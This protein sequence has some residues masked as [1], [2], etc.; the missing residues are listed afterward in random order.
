[1]T[2]LQPH[3][4][5]NFFHQITLIPRPSKKEEKI[6]AFLVDFAN[7][8]QLSSVK[9][10]VGNLVISKP[11]TSAYVNH[12]TVIL[13]AHIDMVC[14]KNAD[15][16]H[17]F[18]TDAIQTYIDGD[19]IKA[20]GTTL[21]ADNGIGVA[22]MLAVLA[23]DN[24][25]HP[26]LECLFTV[27]EETGLT[28]ANG[29]EKNL[30]KGLILINLDSEDDGE[31]FIGCA[32]GIGTKA[33][34]SYKTEPTPSGLFGFMIKVS[35]LT[36]GHS[37]SDIHLGLGNAIKIL[38]RFLWQVN[39]TM[40]LRI[41]AFEGGNLHNAIPREAFAHAAVPYHEKETIR[42]MLNHYIVDSEELLKD[43]EPK[44]RI[45][46]ESD[47]LPDSVMEKAASD[48]I[49]NTL[50]A[51]PHGV[52]AM[53]K[54]MLGMVETSTNLASV[55]M[56]ENQVIEINTS[57]R[58][59]FEYSKMDIAAQ[60]FAVFELAGATVIQSD[61]YPSWQPNLKSDILKQT[62]KA[63]EL[64]FQETPKIKVIHA[65]LE[66]GLFLEKYPHL[67]MISIGPQMYGV[68]SPDERLNIASTQKTWKWLVEILKSC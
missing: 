13:Q 52:I 46:L 30:L 49:L 57:Q 51:C 16:V 10:A 15:V 45:T 11:A 18:D 44:L 56:K 48:C 66:C 4:L 19:W 50:Y 43:I 22:M 20:K 54:K 25:Q 67:D 8:H 33:L 59:S 39:Q 2:E 27:D 17:N 62:T 7:Q 42:V 9:D 1:M 28:G 3:S 60:I 21:G 12:P 61:G 23:A 47:A 58:S 32:G 14:E 40:D 53:S 68:H 64:L 55:K 63:Y 38:N 6:S 41:I 36:G 5:W 24:L 31:I 29:L 35:G 65:G 37:G 26:A 34:L